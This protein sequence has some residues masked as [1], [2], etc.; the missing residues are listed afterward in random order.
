[1]RSR[2][3]Q[4]PPFAGWLLRRLSRAE[5]R[6][7]LEGDFDEEFDWRLRTQGAARARLWYWGHIARSGPAFIL[8]AVYWRTTMFK[9]YWTVAWR[10]ISK[11]KGYAF[12]KTIG[13]A[14]GIACCLLIYL[15]VRRELSYD[16]YHRDEKRIFRVAQKIQRESGELDTA[17]VA[18]PLIP[19]LREGFPEVESAAR[20][21]LATWDSLVERGETKAYEDWV[22]IAENDIF[23]VFSIPFKRG[24]S[25]TALDRRLTVVITER[26][27]QKYFGHEDPVGQTLV[28]WGKTVEVTGVVEDHPDNTHLRYD[29]IIS[30]NSFEKTWN[31]DNWGWT[32]FYAYVKLKP[33]VDP[34]G[35]ER[36][37]RHIADAHAGGEP[38]DGGESSAFYLQPVASIHLR[39]HLISE[40]G[41]P[42]DP[43]QVLVI[44]VLGMLI[45]ILSCINFTNLAT[46]RSAN[47]AREVG[48]RK[49]VGAARGQLTRQFLFESILVSLA[50]SVMAL[51]LSALALPHFNRLTGQSLGQ[52]DVLRPAVLVGLLGLSVLVGFMAG[53]YPAFL[54]ARFRPVNALKGPQGPDSR[55]N[56]LRKALV[57]LQY[58]I[59]IALVIG[60]LSVDRQVRFMKNRD[61][62]FDKYQKLIVPADTADMKTK[63]EAVKSEFL[64]S[65]F[66]RGATAC[67]NV[68]G[69]L[70]NLIEARLV[71]ETDEKAQS[72]NFYYVDA[73]FFSEYKIGMAAGRPF[74]K[75]NPTD[76][77]D[78]FVL[79]ES[80]AKALG[81]ASPGEAL[82]KRMYEGG[83]GGTGTIVGVARDFHY[84]G[85][86][87][88]VEP[89]VLQ[90]KPVMFERLSLTVKT[91][92]LSRTISFVEKKWKELRLGSLFTYFFL[93]EDFDRLYGAEE[94]LGR[95]SATLTFLAVFISCMGLAGLSALV[96]EQRTKEIGIRKVLGASGPGIWLLLVSEFTKWVLL[97]NI[98]AWPLSYL[99]I[100]KWLQGFAYRSSVAVW[101]FGLSAAAAFFVAL[102]TVT[103]Q[104]VRAAA[105]DPVRALR[106]E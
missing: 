83:S 56:A 15:H 43:R 30:L 1:M 70:A 80:A 39:S 76:V 46:A 45:L 21:Q 57:T 85:L 81:F 74:L 86:Q 68:P 18:T 27:A 25:E 32:G 61:L 105:A 97:A 38:A 5:D 11:H 95:L 19:A 23:D 65:P 73:D 89:L 67:W 88:R 4:P 63:Y 2:R 106:Y 104:S 42:G 6:L 66:V 47:R 37:I 78:A 55:G 26:V 7:S 33:H 69:R 87:T 54:L 36:K 34:K 58:S 84:K 17:R 22:M 102:M 48:V 24:H 3:L 79:N 96:A 92:D 94:S 101:I 98:I 40:I 20:F 51:L 100:H 103:Y 75:Q 29:V 53:C 90:W 50:S 91:E 8:N 13:L 60:T 35:F 49:A 82:G 64:A 72:M 9:N 16:R 62:G 59:T 41:T 99:V 44:S 14:L 77:V 12:I 52:D 31:L 10:N 28:L 93:D 71:E